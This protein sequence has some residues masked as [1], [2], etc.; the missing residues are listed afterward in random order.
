MLLKFIWEPWQ[1]DGRLVSESF[2]EPSH[3]CLVYWSE[4][5][6]G[7]VFTWKEIMTPVWQGSRLTAAKSQA[8][9]KQPQKEDCPKTQSHGSCSR[10]MKS[11]HQI[12]S[13]AITPRE[14]K[15]VLR[16]VFAV[17]F[18]ITGLQNSKV[19]ILLGNQ[20]E[21]QCLQLLHDSQAYLLVQLQVLFIKRHFII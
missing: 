14:Y 3:D 15:C 9:C 12:N 21:N 5:C 1:L 13:D 2:S 18:Q 6:S 8:K 19:Y 16:T 17:S 11:R 10:K 20:T 4:L 7:E